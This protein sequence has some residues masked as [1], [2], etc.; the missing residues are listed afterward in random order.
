[1]ELIGAYLKKSR[2]ELLLGEKIT[3]IGSPYVLIR[4]FMLSVI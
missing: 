3:A 1:M 4:S 2:E